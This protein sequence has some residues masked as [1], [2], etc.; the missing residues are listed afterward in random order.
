MGVSE[1]IVSILMASYNHAA[2]VGAAIESVQRQ[3]FAAWE[4][5]VADDASTDHTLEVLASY[6]ADARLRV[7]PFRINR[8]HHMRNYAAAQARGDYL[9]FL[10]SDD[11]F[12]PGKLQQQIEVLE[13]NPQV[14]AVFTHVQCIDQH[15]RRLAGHS[16]ERVFAVDN[17][18]RLQWLRRFFL[19]GNCLCISSA[20]VR[21]ACFHEVG[22]FNPLLIQ[23]GDLDLWIRLGLK[24]DLHVIPEPL[25]AMR[26]LAGARNL[27][28]PGPATSSRAIVE[29]QQVY[30]RF[31]STDGL[32]QL[33]TVFPELAPLLR[34]D[35][36]ARRCY[37]L[38]RLATTLPHQALR[39]LGF[40]KLHELLRD[41]QARDSLLSGNPRLLR[42]LFLSEGM[43]ALDEDGPG[44]WWTVRLPAGEDSGAPPVWTFWTAA[45]DRGTVCLSIPNP[46]CACRLALG[47][48]ARSVKATC[49]RLC[50]YDPRTGVVILDTADIPGFVLKAVRSRRRRKAARFEGQ[51]RRPE[52]RGRRCLPQ[53]DFRAFVSPE[54][55]IEAEIEVRDTGTYVRQRLRNV[56]KW[57]RRKL[58]DRILRKNSSSEGQGSGAEPPHAGGR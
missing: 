36:P 9:A 58:R 33:P 26:L 39:L 1:P 52:S 10:N 57:L 37:V 21:R 31:F 3:E 48:E 55:D 49:R 56:R 23:V 25:T 16:L 12:L 18:S 47:L 24:W 2:H 7:F 32:E 41:G 45:V 13:S 17:Q 35:S 53:I 19:T 15:G 20:M 44:L 30:D 4:L 46:D 38:G 27:S 54:I 11:L 5:L 8:E 50:L 40:R 6:A 43:A 28:A 34:E 29:C 51:T 22:G 14:A 42:M